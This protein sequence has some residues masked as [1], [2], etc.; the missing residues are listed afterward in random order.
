MAVETAAQIAAFSTVEAEQ[1]FVKGWVAA[2]VQKPKYRAVLE[3]CRTISSVR[4]IR[5]GL[6]FRYSTDRL[7]TLM[8]I[9]SKA[10]LVTRQWVASPYPRRKMVKYK[11]AARGERLLKLAPGSKSRLAYIIGG[12]F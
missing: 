10:G 3:G 12:D 7:Y 2:V 4:Q 5:A 9:F 1:D 6:K 11:L 8:L